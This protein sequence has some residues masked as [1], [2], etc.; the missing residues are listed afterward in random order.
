MTA[1]T[2]LSPDTVF[3]DAGEYSPRNLR[4]RMPGPIPAIVIMGWAGTGT[5]TLCELLH[6]RFFSTYKKLSGGDYQRSLAQHSKL[7]DETAIFE[8]AKNN[9]SDPAKG[10]D[11]Q[12]EK[13][14]VTEVWNAFEPDSPHDGVIIEARCGHIATFGHGCNIMLHCNDDIR[15]ERVYDREVARALQKGRTSPARGEV[16]K[17]R[18]ERDE[19]DRRLF[20]TYPGSDYK[21]W[22][23]C[24]INTGV[25]NAES[26]L[27]FALQYINNWRQRVGLPPYFDLPSLACRVSV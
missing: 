7:D 20:E 13:F 12:C 17:M 9:A 4:S 5:S 2:E 22:Q 27:Q 24:E 10:T 16:K 26:T 23:F 25:R 18:R 21:N 6:E 8:Q 1:T 3:F 19:L 15:D 14:L 11:H